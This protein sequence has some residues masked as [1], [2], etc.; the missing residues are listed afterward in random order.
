MT[1]SDPY[2]FRRA[3]PADIALLN[4]WRLLSHVAEWWDPEE[5][6]DQEDFADPRVVQWV[7][8]FSGQPFAFMQDYTVHGWEDHHF[9][10]LPTGSRGIDHFIGP[11]EMVG[12]GHGTAFIRQRLQALFGAGA[13]VI[14]TDPHPNNA[15]AIAVYQK[16]GFRTVGP[17]RETEWGLIVPMLAEP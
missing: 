2:E 7:V 10:G 4:T 17:P 5:L 16:L 13:P 14:A 3:T 1:G 6:F 8:S 12:I 9:A 11:T 15:R